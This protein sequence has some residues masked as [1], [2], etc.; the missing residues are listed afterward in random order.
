[1]PTSGTGGGDGDGREQSAVGLPA[2]PE[3]DQLLVGDLRPRGRGPEGGGGARGFQPRREGLRRAPADDSAGLR[4][5]GS[6]V[7]SEGETRG[8]D[9]SPLSNDQV[10][11]D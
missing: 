1:M 9:P 7:S 8:R 11:G 5:G 6:S 10:I 4:A 3:R 2:V